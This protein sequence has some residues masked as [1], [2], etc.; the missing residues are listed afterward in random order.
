MIHTAVRGAEKALTDRGND[1]TIY[2]D[3]GA[4]LLRGA[5]PYAVVDYIY[6]PFFAALVAPLTLLPAPWQVG[7]WQAC[8]VLCAL[9]GIVGAARLVDPRRVCWW[10]APATLFLTLRLWNSNFAYGQAN[11]FTFAAL[12]A[13][14]H[15]LRRGRDGWAG[16]LVGAAAAFKIVPLLAAAVLVARRRWRALAATAAV[17]AG[18]LLGAPAALV[19]ARGALELHREWYATLAGPY[20][21]GG[22]ALLAAHP[23]LAG[24]S[25]LASFHRA[26]SGTLVSATNAELR[27]TIVLL[28][29]ATVKLLVRLWIAAHLIALC[30]LLLRSAALARARSAS[31]SDRLDVDGALILCTAL[32]VAPLV[33]KAHMSWSALAFAVLLTRLAAARGRR[34]RALIGAP[35]VLAALAIGGTARALIGQESALRCLAYDSIFIGVE[36]LWVGLVAASLS[37]APARDLELETA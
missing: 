6:L 35:L 26:F 5:S 37:K 36:L 9:A 28:P 29:P 31:A 16:A 19:G 34:E 12:I 7:I 15:A 32:I 11:A 13:A 18:L 30:A 14:L 10:L 27:A 33:H 20:V 3:A 4:A 21:E 23:R 1:L 17:S 22:E 25:A 24:Q 2:L 8:S